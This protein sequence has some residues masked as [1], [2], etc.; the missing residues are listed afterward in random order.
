MAELVDEG[1][2]GFWRGQ[3]LQAAVVPVGLLV[4]EGSDAEGSVAV[5]V[6][7]GGGLLG[8]EG[9]EDSEEEG[10]DEVV[11]DDDGE[12]E[13]EFAEDLVLLGLALPLGA[14]EPLPIV[15]HDI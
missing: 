4:A 11:P 10:E 14:V 5:E 12:F 15:G 8:V 2:G 1:G 7:D 9:G 6:D 3:S 13:A